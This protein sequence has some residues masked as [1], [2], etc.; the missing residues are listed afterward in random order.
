MTKKITLSLLVLLI[1]SAFVFVSCS[2]EAGGAAGGGGGGVPGPAPKPKEEVKNVLGEKVK[3]IVDEKFE[4]DPPYIVKGDGATI[5]KA[6]GEGIEGSGALKVTPNFIY[7]QVA[8]DMTK[9]YARGKSYYIEAWFKNAGVEGARTDDL[10]A[11]IDFSIVT[12]AGINYVGPSGY[13][14][15]HQKGQEYDVPGQYDGS[16]M[17]IEDAATIFGD[18]EYEINFDPTSG[19]QDIEDGWTKVCAILDAE[20]IETVITTEDEKCHATEEQAGTLYLFNIIFLVGTYVDDDNEAAPNVGQN[21]YVYYMDNIK[22]IDLNDDLDR[23]GKTYEEPEPEDPE[24]E[25]NSGEE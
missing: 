18:D 7:G 2:Q 24:E 19:G 14:T 6:E 8:I 4:T 15:T 17:P 16:L 10:N 20:S 11:K 5:E 3:V 25:E 1:I 22:I 9:Y 13:G 21:G 23:E 12:G